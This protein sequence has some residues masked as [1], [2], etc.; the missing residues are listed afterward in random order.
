[1]LEFIGIDPATSS[2][3][4][5]AVFIDPAT[6]DLLFLGQTVTD[7]VMLA[8]VARHSP[9]GKDES[10]VRLPARMKAIILEAVSASNGAVVQ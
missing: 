3:N 1:M 7:R 5:P 4:C 10:A 9:I 8:E 2:Q 6:G